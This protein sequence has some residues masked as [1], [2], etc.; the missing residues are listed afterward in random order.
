MDHHFRSKGA[1]E[2][3]AAMYADDQHPPSPSADLYFRLFHLRNRVGQALKA[4]HPTEF[5]GTLATYASPTREGALRGFLRNT[6]YYAGNYGAVE[7]EGPPGYH[8][9]PP[10]HHTTTPPHHH[11]TTTP[12][13]YHPT[14][15]CTPTQP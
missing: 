15:V 4:R 1:R 10:T 5:I 13:P 6:K 2:T 9:A 7:H 14:T 3:G 11:P 8:P 12:P